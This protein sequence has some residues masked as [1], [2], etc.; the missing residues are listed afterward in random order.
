[1]RIRLVYSG[2]SHVIS[3]SENISIRGLKLAIT[4]AL[5][6]CLVLSSISC[7]YP[8]KLLDFPEETLIS[9]H[10]HENEVLR[11]EVGILC[12]TMPYFS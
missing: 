1:M 3:V 8:P 4:D 6:D 9:E 10:I 11:L 2:G 5:G 12:S 7:G